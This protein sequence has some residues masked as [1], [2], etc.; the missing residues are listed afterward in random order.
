V[1]APTPNAALAYRNLTIA[2]AAAQPLGRRLVPVCP[3]HGEEPLESC[4]LC[5]RAEVARG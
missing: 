5:R 3:I 2:R 1:T 4:G